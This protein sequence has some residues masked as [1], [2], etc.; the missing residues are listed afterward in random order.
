MDLVEIEH[1]MDLVKRSE[2]RELTLKQG[3]ARLTLKKQLNVTASYPGAEE[4]G[5]YSPDGRELVYNGDGSVTAEVIEGNEPVTLEINS[6]L[7]GVF[8]HIKPMVGLGANV[9]SGQVIAV[10]EAMKL[11]TDINSSADG[12]VV[13]TYV[14]DGMPVEY[15]QPLFGIKVTK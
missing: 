9:K 14:E 2:I 13:E 1:L 10:I 15:G 5:L 4:D 7:V 3:D 8:R 6:P 12:V 11:N